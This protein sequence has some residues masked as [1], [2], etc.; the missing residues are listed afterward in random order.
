[1]RT[2]RRYRN[3]PPSGLREQTRLT[4]GGEALLA[5]RE[6]TATGT[7]VWGLQLDLETGQFFFSHD[8]GPGTRGRLLEI[9]GVL[10]PDG[11]MD[12][13]EA[14]LRAIGLANYLRL[15]EM[16]LRVFEIYAEGR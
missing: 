6:P 3:G 13:S 1:M 15:Q 5:W 11:R 9:G 2:R 16:V 12:V 14:D 7:P 4:S 10:E 8:T